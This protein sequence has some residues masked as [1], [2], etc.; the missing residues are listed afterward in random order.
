[1]A[2]L[3]NT[4]KSIT[5][6]PANTHGWAL[7]DDKTTQHWTR[8]RDDRAEHRADG[9]SSSSSSST[10]HGNGT[11]A[12]VHRIASKRRP[13]KAP[14]LQHAAANAAALERGEP[15]YYVVFDGEQS[16]SYLLLLDGQTFTEVNRSYL[17]FKVPFSF[18]GNWFPELH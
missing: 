7:G 3:A 12:A 16:R 4:K 11:S 13:T 14:P 1:M 8:K 10:W 15:T 17:P 2:E 9:S 6:Q 18:H 5:I